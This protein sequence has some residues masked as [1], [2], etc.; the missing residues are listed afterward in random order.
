MKHV[1][2]DIAEIDEHPSPVFK[3]FHP[4]ERDARFLAGV[5]DFSGDRLD[6]FFRV[7]VADDEVIGHDRDAFHV[8]DD[9]VVRP[10]VVRC[11]GDETGQC[12]TLQSDFP[13]LCFQSFNRLPVV[14]IKSL[15]AKSVSGYTS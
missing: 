1:N 9:N 10:F 4:F 8:Q 14:L 13:V 6:L 5:F 15:Y 3:A 11:A 12:F 7:A 2:D